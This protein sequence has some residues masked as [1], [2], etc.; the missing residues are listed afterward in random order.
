MKFNKII[1]TFNIQVLQDIG[2]AIAP[3]ADS[4]IQCLKKCVHVKSK[5]CSILAAK[6]SYA[7]VFSSL[8]CNVM[9]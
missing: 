1:I 5:S 9:S 4:L 7:Y 3:F 6:V 2:G 8:D